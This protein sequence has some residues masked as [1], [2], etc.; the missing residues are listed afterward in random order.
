MNSQQSLKAQ[1][2]QL[3]WL[4]N[5][6]GL[7][8]AVDFIKVFIK[9]QEAINAKQHKLRAEKS[10]KA[11]NSVSKRWEYERNTNVIRAKTKRNTSI[12]EY[13]KEEKNN[14]QP[15]ISFPDWLPVKTFNEYLLCRKKKLKK[16]AYTRFFNK[17]KKLSDSTG[18]TPEEILD[19]SI[20]NG[21]EGIFEVKAIYNGSTKKEAWEV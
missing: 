3:Y 21:W 20:A 15:E 1:L 17:L 10:E 14:K 18:N 13:S 16:E 6:A 8:D 12:V 19:Q 11:I 2:D 9:K 7:Y 4:G 5:K